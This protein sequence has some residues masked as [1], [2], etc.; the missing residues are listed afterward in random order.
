MKKA[1]VVDDDDVTLQLIEFLL[2]KNGYEVITAV[3]GE[4]G[5]LKVKNEHPDIVIMD[6]MMPVLDGVEACKKIKAEIGES[7]PPV[8]LL[9]ALGQDAEVIQ[10][11]KSGAVSF[12]TKPFDPKLLLKKIVDNLK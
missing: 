6:I 11:I 9:T 8:I 1:L 10:G 2:K 7:A 12:M 5:F 3:N 4:D